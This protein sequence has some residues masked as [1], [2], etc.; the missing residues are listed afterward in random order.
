MQQVGLAPVQSSSSKGGKRELYSDLPR[1]TRNLNSLVSESVSSIISLVSLH[2]PNHLVH[3]STPGDEGPVSSAL[4]CLLHPDPSVRSAVTKQIRDVFASSTAPDD[5]ASS[6][7]P[8]AVKMLKA[9]NSCLA[10]WSDQMEA[11]TAVSVTTSSVPSVA[12]GGVNEE[13]SAGQSNASLLRAQLGIPPSSRLTEAL[14]VIISHWQSTKAGKGVAD[15]PTAQVM[16]IMLLACSHPL[17]CESRVRASV[18]WCNIISSFATSETGRGILD[19]DEARVVVCKRMLS[20]ALCTTARLTRQAAHTALYVLSTATG[21]S[22]KVCV[23]RHILPSLRDQLAN[24]GVT[25]VCDD[26]VDKFLNPLA[27]IA[28]LT[29]S[30]AETAD[31]DIRITNADRKKDSG[32]SR[33]TG[34]FGGDFVEDE[35]WAEKIKKEKAQ[36]LAITKNAGQVGSSAKLKEL[37]DLQS[38]VQVI[39]DTASYALEAFLSLTTFAVP[40]ARFTSEVA[41]SKS[42]DDMLLRGV[43]RSS[44][45]QMLPV[46]LPMLRCPLIEKVA[47]QCVLGISHA[48]EDELTVV[49]S[50]DLADSLRI[51]ATVSMRPVSRKVTRDGLY[52]ELL[53]LAAP[54]QRLLRSVQIH[55]SR[56][57]ARKAPTQHLLLPSTVHLLFPVLKGLLTQPSLLPGCDFAFMILDS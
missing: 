25:A 7:Y 15:M 35:D 27:A 3:P 18:V 43:V 37:Q 21:A 31:A 22:G 47:F 8:T 57:Q 56:Q 20:A 50:R 48:I 24:S 6:Q 26:D 41:D 16:S 40:H 36:K 4:S 13:E 52:K 28:A 51:T 44:V 39:V 46:L 42:S 9:L 32:R 10:T 14:L 53:S 38:R 29:A 1:G 23:L 30:V 19:T 2:H 34:A 17:V 11:A 33:R 12:I 54:L 55:L 5:K 45:S 49:A